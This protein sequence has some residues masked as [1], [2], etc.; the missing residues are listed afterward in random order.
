MNK[1]DYVSFE[2]AKLLKKKCFIYYTLY[3][4]EKNGSIGMM[5]LAAQSQMRK[6]GYMKD[7]YPRPTLYE[8]QKWLIK[9]HNLFVFISNNE[10]GFYWGLNRADDGQHVPIN[11]IQETGGHNTYEEA[12]NEGILE[13]LKL[14]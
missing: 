11:G 14:I 5:T 6:H 8:A 12:L 3:Y 7:T 1:E 9:E 10:Y 4:Y 13:A 2:V